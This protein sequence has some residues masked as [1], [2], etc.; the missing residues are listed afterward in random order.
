[1]YE[2]TISC[3][4]HDN[5][6]LFKEQLR[7]KANSNIAGITE[8]GVYLA[9]CEEKCCITVESISS[10]K[11]ASDA[12]SARS[13][14]CLDVPL[15]EVLSGSLQPSQIYITEEIVMELF[16]PKFIPASKVDESFRKINQH[17]TAVLFNTLSLSLTDNHPD[18]ICKHITESLKEVVS[19]VSEK[20]VKLM[21][22]SRNLDNELPYNHW[23]HQ[24]LEGV[25]QSHGFVVDMQAKKIKA[26]APVSEYVSSQPDVMIFHADKFSKNYNALYVKPMYENLDIL[27]LNEGEDEIIE[28]VKIIGFAGELK[29]KRMGDDVENECFYNMF[30]QGV[31][32]AM[33]AMR[34]G[35]IVKRVSMFGITIAVHKPSVSRLLHVVMD[36]D[37]NRCIFRR[38]YNYYSFAFLI[39]MVLNVLSQE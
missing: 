7:E 39:N 28:E 6:K 16:H 27:C 15:R 11:K 36:F 18:T 38:V 13:F 33:M 20:H 2:S 31:N 34:T 32:L 29:V 26:I 1:M 8:R 4:L 22:T 24:H 5:K 9:Y 37:S 30:G 12:T 3:N 35:Q 25:L 14:E 21:T 19:D 23:L 17:L 10:T